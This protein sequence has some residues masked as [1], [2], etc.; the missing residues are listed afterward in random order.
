MEKTKILF[1]TTI[2]KSIYDNKLVYFTYEEMKISGKNSEYIKT[3]KID[4]I[5]EFYILFNEFDVDKNLLDEKNEE[6]EEYEKGGE[7]KE[8]KRSIKI[9]L[10]VS[11]CSNEDNNRKKY[12]IIINYQSN[13]I[14]FIFNLDIGN[15]T[16]TKLYDDTRFEKLIIDFNKN[17]QI[18]YKEEKKR[19][20][21]YDEADYIENLAK[22]SLAY[23]EE[24]KN[25]IF[26]INFDIIIFLLIYIKNSKDNNMSISTLLEACNLN[27]IT[28][29][30]QNYIYNKEKINEFVKEI[31]TNL[32]NDQKAWPFNEIQAFENGNDEENQEDENE[33]EN[34]IEDTKNM[35]AT[36]IIFIK[37]ILGYYSKFGYL[38]DMKLF[39]MNDIIKNKTI[40]VLSLEVKEKYI[41]YSFRENFMKLLDDKGGILEKLKLET[42]ILE[43][44]KLISENFSVLYELIKQVGMKKYNVEFQNINIDTELYDIKEIHKRIIEKEKKNNNYFLNFTPFIQKC[45]YVF[46]GARLDK[47]ILLNEFIDE[48]TKCNNS[49]EITNIKMDLGN[50]IK[51]TI[52][53]YIEFN[54]KKYNFFLLEKIPE[55][56]QY[57]DEKMRFQILRNNN[58]NSNNKE[59]AN[60]IFNVIITKK[61]YN[62]F[63]NKK[64]FFYNIIKNIV[65][66]EYFNYV[67]QIA[68]EI[69]D[70]A[71]E[72]YAWV[73]NNIKSY[74]KE[75]KIDIK[76]DLFK[77][78]CYLMNYNQG[79]K[80]LKIIQTSI[81]DQKVIDIYLYFL[82][83]I[84]THKLDSDNNNYQNI[85]EYFFENKNY[86]KIIPRLLSNSEIK[87]KEKMKDY[88]FNK[89]K[90]NI[91]TFEEFYSRNITQNIK[92]LYELKENEFFNDSKYKDYEYTEKTKNII[93]KI[94]LDFENGDLSF[95]KASAIFNNFVEM[96]EYDY[97][98]MLLFFGKDENESENFIKLSKSFS[99]SVSKF[100]KTIKDLEEIKKYFENFYPNSKQNEIL[101]ID[102]LI[103]LFKNI[104]LKLYDEIKTKDE[105]KNIINYL[106]EAAKNNKLNK[107]SLCFKKIYE[108][109]KIINQINKLGQKSDKD[110]ETLIMKNTI[111][112]FNNLKTIFEREKIENIND[113]IKCLLEL[114]YEYNDDKLLYDEI[115]FL[116]NYFNIKMNVDE[117][118]TIHLDLKLFALTNKINYILLGLLEIKEIFKENINIDDEEEIFIMINNYLN[119]IKNEN[120]ELK[121]LDEIISFLKRFN[122]F[123][124]GEEKTIKLRKTK[125][126]IKK[127]NNIYEKQNNE[128]LI[129]YSKEAEK[130]NNDINFNIQNREIF[131]EFLKLI[132]NNPESLQ[133]AK[134][135]NE[136]NAKF[137]LEFLVESDEKKN[138]QEKDVH[139]FIKT[140]QLLEKI[141]KTKNKFSQLIKLINNAITVPND[142]N[143]L[144][145]YIN[146]YIRNFNGIKSLYI[147]SMD[148]SG[149][150]SLII[151]SILTNSL[152]KVTYNNITIEYYKNNKDKNILDIEAL[153]ELRGKAVIMK[154]YMKINK[155]QEIALDNN[156]NNVKIFVDLIQK[157]KILNN[158]LYNLYNIGIPEPDNYIISINITEK[159]IN[160]II[161]ENKFDYSDI[162]CFMCGKKY[163]INYL[164]DHFLIS[165]DE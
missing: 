94:K 65:G 83:N 42:N 132:Q 17:F 8:N 28:Y 9:F 101:N 47:L 88:I 60:N 122:I 113:N 75:L 41:S 90:N 22:D 68:S 34:K 158:Y 3:K 100:H 14:N 157:F 20:N 10:I 117:I 50:K 69:N 93:G 40:N 156:Y 112:K 109:E 154:S 15:S 136:K 107:R 110:S 6:N 48:E 55:M 131:C 116:K 108:N 102:N 139:G 151:A 89:L 140:I 54:S 77:V 130:Q 46:E 26:D 44:F 58:L 153:E 127:I 25:D 96:K 24:E 163:K 144:G 4:E 80:L 87:Q 32:E 138:L 63:D 98:F 106:D 21:E 30:R 97:K 78:F 145:E 37:I 143:Y 120:I 147:D 119:D 74:K 36:E 114:F 155:E 39:L 137:L 135:Q 7:N 104:K 165:R 133:F 103:I 23:L 27:K 57:L 128:Q 95:Q 160:K 164:I 5:N 61:L 2:K 91:I 43:Y 11:N 85:I 82:E 35:N 159:D 62:Y 152:A 18:F 64:N 71:N 45:I 86:P 121:K 12:E 125:T 142:A 51:S 115:I 76:H 111:K 148:K 31:F 99:N 149:S 52:N 38:D 129:N 141:L 70:L 123:L 53:I 66:L 161:K 72:L 84:I 79:N 150:S 124:L 73:S 134:S 146:N 126:E 81:N 118:K 162:E 67:V 56:N 105:Y 16:K 59:D 1:L 92:L 19:N 49:N 29:D 13:K 33:K